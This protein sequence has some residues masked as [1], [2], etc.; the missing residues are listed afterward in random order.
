[1][2]ATKTPRHE[3][4][5]SRAIAGLNLDGSPRLNTLPTAILKEAKLDEAKLSFFQ[6]DGGEEGQLVKSW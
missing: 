3:D 4:S 6:D 1:M 2:I 5:Q